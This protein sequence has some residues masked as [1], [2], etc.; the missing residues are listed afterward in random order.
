MSTSPTSSCPSSGQGLRPRGTRTSRSTGSG[1]RPPAAGATGPSIEVG[2][3]QSGSEGRRYS[4]PSSPPWPSSDQGSPG[5]TPGGKWGIGPRRNIM[6]SPISKMGSPISKMGVAGEP[7]WRGRGETSAFPAPGA[8]LQID[9]CKRRGATGACFVGAGTTLEMRPALGQGPS[10]SSPT[11][12]QGPSIGG[13]CRTSRRWIGSLIDKKGSH[14][15]KK[16]EA[17]ASPGLRPI[18]GSLTNKWRKA[19]DTSS[20]GAAGASPGVRSNIS[21]V[22]NKRREVAGGSPIIKMGSP[23]IKKME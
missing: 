11:T 7:P 13:T 16:R 23:I 18:P 21:L 12:G 8:R 4:L 14:I 1:L 10:S 17:G 22:I 9:S 5:A 6:G 2:V 15:T 3:E 20:T 19:V